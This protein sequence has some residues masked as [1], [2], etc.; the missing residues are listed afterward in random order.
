MSGVGCGHDDDAGGFVEAVH[1]GQDLIE[2]LFA[3]I[4]SAADA[5]KTVTSH[6]IDFIDEEQAGRVFTALIKQVP[7]ATGP[8]ADKHLHKFAAGGGEERHTGFT[9]NRF[10]QEGFARARRAI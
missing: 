4:V 8:D 10:G 5:G 7:H 1:L 6:G 9:G 2:G 3:F